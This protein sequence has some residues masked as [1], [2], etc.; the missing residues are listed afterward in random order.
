MV[1]RVIWDEGLGGPDT[2][3]A[4]QQELL[5]LNVDVLLRERSHVFIMKYH[6]RF[7]LSKSLLRCLVLHGFYGG[8]DTGFGAIDRNF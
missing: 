3:R 2:K 4:Q 8:C 1:R 6:K 5:G 7:V